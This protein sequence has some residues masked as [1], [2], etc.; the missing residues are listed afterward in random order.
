MNR[1]H[2]TLAAILLLASPVAAAESALTFEKDVRPILKAYCFECHGEGEKLRGGLDLRLRRLLVQGGDSGPTIEPSK[3]ND[4]LLL[5]RLQAGEMPPGKKKLTK[6]EIALIRRW[7]AA[8]AKTSGAEPEALTTGFHITAEDRAFWAYQ[9]IGRP[10]V[11]TVRHGG[12]VRTPLDAF[13]LARLEDIG[14]SFSTE[15]DRATLIR[16]ACFD[17]IGL[18]PTPAEVSDFLADQRPDAYE[19]WI[20]RLLASPHYGERWGRHWLDVAGYADSDGYSTEDAI[21]PWAHKYRDYVIRSFNADKPFNQFIVE[22]LAGDE[23]VKP[24]YQ[25]LKPEHVWADRS[26][27]PTVISVT[28]NKQPCRCCSCCS[29]CPA[30]SSRRRSASR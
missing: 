19:Q 25:N 29:W 10:E 14:M 11:P 2:P 5:Q 24:P 16:R 3:P 21:R 8:G 20:D 26:V 4:S 1:T 9:P 23:L 17:L 12:R 30:T 18:P 28:V 6:D 7:I 15:A 13:L 22:Q 27:C